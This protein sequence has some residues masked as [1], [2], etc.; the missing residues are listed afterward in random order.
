MLQRGER[1]ASGSRTSSHLC[2]AHGGHAGVCG[3]S[4]RLLSA[5][6]VDVPKVQACITI[7]IIISHN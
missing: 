3:A 4:A 2:L 5:R 1:F 6:E 7:F